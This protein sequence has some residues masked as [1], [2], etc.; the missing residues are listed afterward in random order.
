MDVAELE[1]AMLL[2]SQR[3]HAGNDAGL[4]QRISESFHEAVESSLF[5]LLPA[6]WCNGARHDKVIFVG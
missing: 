2:T 5:D 1:Q 6:S 4:E 3:T